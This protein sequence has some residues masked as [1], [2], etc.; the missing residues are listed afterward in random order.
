MYKRRQFM[1][2]QD[3]DFQTHLTKFNN[4]RTELKRG[5]L[6]YNKCVSKYNSYISGFPVSFIAAFHKKSEKPSF[7]HYFK[8]FES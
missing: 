8:E 7:T 1:I 5:S 6:E 4:A 3:E 2:E